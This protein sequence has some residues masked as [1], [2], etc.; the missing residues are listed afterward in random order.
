MTEL[1]CRACGKTAVPMTVIWKRD[2][3]GSMCPVQAV[4]H[5]CAPPLSAGQIPQAPDV[6]RARVRILTSVRPGRCERCGHGIR[7]GEKIARMRD[8]TGDTY[9]H[10]GCAGQ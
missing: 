1:A 8:G 6:P 3:Y 10:A 9:V 4:C 2:Q 7:Q 5:R